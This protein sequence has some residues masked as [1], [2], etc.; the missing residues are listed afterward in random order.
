MA[1]PKKKRNPQHMKPPIW[2][3]NED[4]QKLER[5]RESLMTRTYQG[6]MWDAI[7]FVYQRLKAHPTLYR[8]YLRASHLP[9]AEGTAVTLRLTDT[10]TELVR[11][12]EEM[13]K[14]NSRTDVYRLCIRM[15]EDWY[16]SNP[17]QG[18]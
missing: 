18:E 7:R 16:V 3:D 10:Q 5:L 6:A 13:T 12:I 17:V 15:A 14:S 4:K 9:Y 2:L 1:S 8:K 11:E